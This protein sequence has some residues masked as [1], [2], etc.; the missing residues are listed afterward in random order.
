MLSDHALVCL[1]TDRSRRCFA[2]VVATLCALTG[3][4]GYGC[5]SPT[6]KT[7]YRMDL[8]YTPDSR[9]LQGKLDLD[10]CNDTGDTLDT[11]C[12]RLWGNAYREGAQHSPISA[13]YRSAYYDGVSY[14]SENVSSV[15]GGKNWTVSE[16]ETLLT[17]EID[18]VAPGEAVSL[19]IEF[20]TTLAKVNHRLGAGKT[21][22]NFGNFY[23]VLCAYEDGWLSPVYTSLGDPFVSE[24][25]DYEVTFTFPD[26][27]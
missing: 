2:A 8:T 25:A 21:C 11:L 22:V 16:D 4:L 26:S 6:G 5:A 9:L 14:G 17:V 7:T 13:A 27:Y 15:E 3:V 10:Y 24:C 18:P 23:P 20:E 1:P 12:F 19:T